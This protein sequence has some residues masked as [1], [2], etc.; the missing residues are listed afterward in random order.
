MVPS[1]DLPT[2]TCAEPETK[3]VLIENCAEP[4]TELIA[5]AFLS[6]TAGDEV[7]N[8]I[9]FGKTGSDAPQPI[10]D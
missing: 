4:D 7:K 10:K 6:T 1:S 3:K 2:S 9:A 8:L 5:V